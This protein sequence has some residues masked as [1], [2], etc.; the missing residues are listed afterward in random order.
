MY[1]PG[2]EIPSGGIGQI[3]NGAI[4]IKDMS[5]DGSKAIVLDITTPWGE[6]FA[7]EWMTT[8]PASNV[9]TKTGSTISPTRNY[10]YIIKLV[11]VN[12]ST[13]KATIQAI[14][15]VDDSSIG[16]FL[17]ITDNIPDS[18]KPGDIIDYEFVITNNSPTDIR[19]RWLIA[20]V[21]GAAG[22]MPIYNGP[23]SLPPATDYKNKNCWYD[24]WAS[25]G[26]CAIGQ[27]IIV[28]GNIKITGS[29]VLS[30]APGLYENIGLTVFVYVPDYWGVGKHE[31][32]RPG[33][34]GGSAHW[35]YID[36]CSGVICNNTCVGDDLW[37]Q[38]CNPSSGICEQNTLIEPSS[39]ICAATHILKLGIKPYS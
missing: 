27:T 38:A 11:D 39:I 26:S 7:D 33:L 15:Y 34:G 32:V 29:M 36:I 6:V 37:S 31:Y 30:D 28:D 5:T 10:K 1:N 23:E 22:S 12:E 25:G 9:T 16:D 21:T 20:S 19:V 35:V 8:D 18:G 2:M 14:S 4:Y 17:P 13:R 24:D 3:A